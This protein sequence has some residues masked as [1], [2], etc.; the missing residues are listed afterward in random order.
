MDAYTGF[1]SVYDIFMDN[2]P[3]D[4]WCEYIV[5]LLKEYG[6]ED[7]IVAELG[8]GTGAMTRRLAKAGYDMIGIDLSSEMLDIAREK[9]E[10]SDGI[11][12]LNQ[13]MRE[14]ELFGTTAAIVS[15]CDS[16][17]YI[18]SEENLR[19]V[20]ELVNNY[21]DP[22][23]LFVFDMN[24]IHKYRDVIGDVT[25]AEN[26]DDCSFIWDNGY[27]EEKNL[28]QYDVTIFKQ[29]EFEEEDDDL[30]PLY[31]KFAETHVQRAYPIATVRRLLEEAGME[32]VAAYDG[33]TKK[34]ASEELT[35]R[36][37]FVAREKHQE[38]KYYQG[39]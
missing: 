10:G 21:L 23:G 37:Y 28:N 38:G 22:R 1:A 14:F 16:M 24:T 26:R 3:Y 2:T 7:G 19:T 12:Y 31:E 27:N 20:F 17:N 29:V 18:T 36:V 6:I 11:L 25:I 39:E 5:G 34:P 30:P 33:C 13:D 35:E 15:L 8:C 9:E 32:F 4:E